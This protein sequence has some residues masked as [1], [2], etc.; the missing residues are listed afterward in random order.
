MKKYVRYDFDVVTTRRNGKDIAVMY[1]I[2]WVY[3][4]GTRRLFKKEYECLD[5]IDDGLPF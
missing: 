2:Y 3:P 5:E 4:D 1:K